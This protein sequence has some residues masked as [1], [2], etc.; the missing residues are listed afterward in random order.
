M[1]TENSGITTNS[2]EELFQNALITRRVD[3]D[4]T[5]EE[6][7]NIQPI[8]QSLQPILVVLKRANKQSIV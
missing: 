5:Q 7:D 1:P 8:L 3:T 4:F 2:S 6:K